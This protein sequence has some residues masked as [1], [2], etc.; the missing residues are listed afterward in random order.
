MQY[1]TKKD[2]GGSGNK[3][4]QTRDEQ[5]AGY[6]LPVMYDNI[7]LRPSQ[8]IGDCSSVRS[9]VTTSEGSQRRPETLGE[10][11]TSSRSYGKTLC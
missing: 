7:I 3:N 9:D 11:L 4:I 5:G 1:M 8:A 10:L 2:Q 6:D